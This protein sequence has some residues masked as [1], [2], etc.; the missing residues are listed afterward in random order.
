M[1]KVKIGRASN[2]QIN[3]LEVKG[4]AHSAEYG[5][6]LVCAAVSAVVTGGFN[7]LNNIDDYEVIL[8]EGHAVFETYTPFDAHDETVIET[9]V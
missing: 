6:D 5:K 2:Q 7:N 9:I 4:H 3:F 8:K 1:I